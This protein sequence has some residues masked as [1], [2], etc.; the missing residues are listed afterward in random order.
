M[1]TYICN[2][3][4]SPD[5][6]HAIVWGLMALGYTLDQS[7]QNAIIGAGLSMQALIHAFEGHTDSKP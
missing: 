5:I 6:W 3:L 4:A 1:K 7:Q 2:M